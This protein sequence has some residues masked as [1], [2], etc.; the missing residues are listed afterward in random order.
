[1][2]LFT[3]CPDL[4][5]AGK[6][7]QRLMFRHTVQQIFLLGQERSRMEFNPFYKEMMQ[8]FWDSATGSV[9]YRAEL[10]CSAFGQP[11]VEQSKC[12]ERPA[13]WRKPAHIDLLARWLLA[14]SGSFVVRTNLG[15]QG[16]VTRKQYRAD[17]PL[18]EDGVPTEAMLRCHLF[19]NPGVYDAALV[20]NH[21]KKLAILGIKMG[22]KPKGN[23]QN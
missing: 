23:N 5:R 7:E 18:F 1:L 9:G 10:C 16:R 14:V 15:I 8:V 2:L 4:E 3:A 6:K 17:N 22:M 11:P 20:E 13:E 12:S 21:G 19:S